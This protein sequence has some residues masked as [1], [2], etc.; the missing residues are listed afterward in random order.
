[1]ICYVPEWGEG[2]AFQKVEEMGKGA[3]TLNLFLTSREKQCD[4]LKI[5]W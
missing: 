5:G 1:M 4:N 2:D 3:A